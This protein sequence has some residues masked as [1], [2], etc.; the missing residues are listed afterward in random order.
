MCPVTSALLTVHQLTASLLD[1]LRKAEVGV[2]CKDQLIPALL[3]VDDLVMFA[4][5]EEML[6]RAL[7]VLG[8]RYEEWSVKV[9]VDKYGVMHM[10][11][12]LERLDKD[13]V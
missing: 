9:N 1:K 3:Y 11:K 6:R 4:E 2:K 13:L 12:G 7:V 10:E 8:E 5:D